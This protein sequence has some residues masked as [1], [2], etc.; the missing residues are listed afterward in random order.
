MDTI[1]IKELHINTIIGVNEDEKLTPQDLFVTIIMG[2][3][4]QDAILSDNLNDTVDYDHLSKDLVSYIKQTRFE[5][6]EALAGACVQK[7]F[8]FSNLIHSIDLVI[9]KPNAIKNS[10]TTEFR[11]IRAR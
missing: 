3:D 7:I 1:S 6:I 11:I 8:N 10:R 4:V 2:V 5:L 9:S